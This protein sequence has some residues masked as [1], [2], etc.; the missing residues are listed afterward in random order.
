MADSIP[1]SIRNPTLALKILSW[2]VRSGMVTRGYGWALAHLPAAL[3][4]G[5][6]VST[7]T[8]LGPFT[9]PLKDPASTGLLLWGC[10]RHE[11]KESALFAALVH[12]CHFV[13]DVGAHMGWYSRLVWGRMQG[14]GQIHA[15]E[16]N[17]AVFSYLQDNTRDRPGLFTHQL[18]V[19]ESVGNTTFYCAASSNLSSAARHVG[20]PIEVGMTAL[21]L[22]SGTLGLIGKIGLI[23]CDV[24]GGELAVLKGARRLRSVA[25]PPIWMLEIDPV[26]LA[27][28]GVS[29]DE[30]NAE[31]SDWGVP[32]K[33]FHLD[34]NGE[35]IAMSDVAQ[36]DGVPNIFVVPESRVTSFLDAVERA[37]S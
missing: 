10:I 5:E 4:G 32:V 26:F 33:L 8:K 35:A 12:E 7:Q 18:A 37:R 27:D 14:D 16:P 9:V 36:G 15:F 34:S 2:A 22:M 23:K 30:L 25:T 13:F 19:G 21:D 6:N 24:E 20:D 17:P 28:A 29:T 1:A 3:W 31:L 11:A